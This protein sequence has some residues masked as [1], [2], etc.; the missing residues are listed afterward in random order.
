MIKEEIKDRGALVSFTYGVR[1]LDRPAIKTD[2]PASCIFSE[3]V[4]NYTL[5]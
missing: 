4:V 3:L 5:C 1:L 2:A